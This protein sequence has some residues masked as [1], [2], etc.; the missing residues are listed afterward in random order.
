[1]LNFALLEPSEPLGLFDEDWW[2]PEGVFLTLELE[3][4]G[5]KN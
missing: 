2:A 1:M 3:S 5:I 4:H